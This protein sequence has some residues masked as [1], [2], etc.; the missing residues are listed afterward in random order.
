MVDE[1]LMGLFVKM[2]NKNNFQLREYVDNKHIYELIIM[3][4]NISWVIAN[5]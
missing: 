2:T 3:F 1:Y 4:G 5:E